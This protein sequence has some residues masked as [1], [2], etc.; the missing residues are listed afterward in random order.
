MNSAF[1][2][3]NKIRRFIKTQGQQF[4]FYQVEQ[5]EFNEPNGQ[6]ESVIISGVYH[7]TTNYLS[8]T[9]S[10]ATTIRQKASP[11][12]LCSWEDAQKL[13]HED[14]LSFNGKQYRV[15]EI[16]NLSEANI[17]GDVSLEEVQYSV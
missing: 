6:T 15:G 10:E 12:I 4:R 1:F 8:K 11:M 2:Q 3:L 14:K 13:T 16:K 5:N 7:E 9:S 17:V